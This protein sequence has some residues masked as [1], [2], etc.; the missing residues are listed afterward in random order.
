MKMKPREYQTD[1]V[2]ALFAALRSSD[3]AAPVAV[4]PT[5]AGKSVVAAMIC[6]RMASHDMRALVLCRTKELVEQ[7]HAAL[8]RLCPHLRSSV[9]C[10]GLK[11]KDTSGSFVFATAQSAANKIEEFG[12]RDLVLIDEAHQVPKRESSQYQKIISGLRE[13]GSRARL[14][15]LTATPYRVDGGAIA[16]DD[17]Q[18]TEIAFE[19]PLREMV[20]NKWLTPLSY[21]DAESVD[22]SG[23][24]IVAGDY[25]DHELGAVFGERCAIHAAEIHSAAES[26][27]LKS[28]LVFASTV[29]HAEALA[30][31]IRDL[32][33]ESTAVIS[34]CT[35]PAQRNET[36]SNFREGRIRYLVNVAVLTTGFDAPGVDMVVLCRAT[37]SHG[38]LYQMLG[39]GM[40][41]ADGKDACHVLDY[42]GHAERLG[43][44]YDPAFGADAEPAGDTDQ[45]DV[46]AGPVTIERQC[47][48][49]Q[50]MRSEMDIAVL[51][52]ERARSK[53]YAD[54]KSFVDHW[55]MCVRDNPRNEL[56]AALQ[57]M[58]VSCPACKKPYTAQLLDTLSHR[59]TQ[60]GNKQ[61]VLLNVMDVNVVV[62]QRSSSHTSA[63]IIFTVVDESGKVKTE[64]SWLTFGSDNSE[65]VV[66]RRWR[67]LFA[68]DIPANPMQAVEFS[69]SQ[70]KNPPSQ[71]ILNNTGRFNELVID[72]VVF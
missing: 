57:G 52:T 2:D 12:Q 31:N 58:L 29:A 49:C 21:I 72:G 48:S 51:L 69:K 30:G 40:R 39:R 42:G 47:T 24:S 67:A 66:S 23:V 65:R 33:G 10:S 60:L 27:N 22:L 15:G 44:I 6:E 4:L 34:G 3:D 45:P 71:V 46:Q 36:I 11:S 41:L 70:E 9:Y 54:A 38:L 59:A 19:K 63:K 14:I 16:G 53:N 25:D 8:S 17:K 28:V 7:N 1:A 32:S 61:P 62:D 56:P 37:Q 55:L 35:K 64:N 5:G 50:H 18:F 68:G 26:N 20:D 43:D 13:N